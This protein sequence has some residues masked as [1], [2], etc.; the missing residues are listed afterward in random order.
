MH[1]LVP[2]FGS[3]EFYN[4][5]M[6]RINTENYI[7]EQFKKGR[8]VKSILKSL[9]TIMLKRNRLLVNRLFMGSKAI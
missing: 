2:V 9:N 6:N 4:F 1:S 7:K 5:L 3:E 8:K